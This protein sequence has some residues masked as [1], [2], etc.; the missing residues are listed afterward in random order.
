MSTVLKRLLIP[1]KNI[2][3][4]DVHKNIIIS[5]S[6]LYPTFYTFDHDELVFKNGKISL[7]SASSVEALIESKD[8]NSKICVLNFAD[9]K[10][11][12]G[13]Y[14]R[15]INTQKENLCYCSNL[16][17][18]LNKK[19]N[20]SYYIYNRLRPLQFL[21]SDY[22][23]YSANIVFYRDPTTFCEIDPIFADVLTIPAPMATYYKLSHP[24]YKPNLQSCLERRI[25]RMFNIIVEN[26]VDILIL[27]AWG[28]V[29]METIRN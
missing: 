18:E 8:I 17:T 27:G 7:E 10:K 25:R 23:I 20:R 13:E 26:N 28:A 15:G 9:A 5:T 14:K 11:P 3:Y 21:Y 24:L 29:H 19:D 12:G 6:R 22:A 16:Y 4:Q 2:K 1:K